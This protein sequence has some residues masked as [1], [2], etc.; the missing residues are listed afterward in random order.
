MS[1]GAIT[2]N[3]MQSFA[4]SLVQP[5]IKLS[6]DV[7]NVIE[8]GGDDLGDDLGFN[9]LANTK[10]APNR[11]SGSGGGGGGNSVSVAPSAFSASDFQVGGLE[12]LEP[13]SIDI[14]GGMGGMESL[15]EVTINKEGGMGGGGGGAMAWDNSQTASGPGIS[16]SAPKRLSPEEERRQK[17]DLINKLGRLESKGFQISKRFTM[18][19]SLDEIEAEFNRLADA[20]QLES[21]MKFQRQMMMGVVTGLELMN[22]KFNPFDWQLEGW[23]ESVHENIDDFDEVFEE[24]YDKY[25]TKGNMPP[26]ARLLFMLV[27]SG[28]MF[29]MSN[30]FFRQKMGNMTMDDLL[31]NNPA[32]AKQ[33]AAAAAQAAGPGFGNFMGAAMGVPQSAPAAPMGMGGMGMGMGG[34]GMGMGGMGGMGGGMPAPMPGNGGP[35]AFFNSAS[36]P[37]TA[38]SRGPQLSPMGA[39]AGAGAGAPAPVRREMKGPSGVDDILQTFQEVRRSEMEAAAAN[40]IFVPPPPHPSMTSG[41]PSAMNA[42]PARA[43]AAELQSIHSEESQSQAGSTM[44]GRT[45]GRRRKAQMPVGN[46]MTLNA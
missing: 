24:L 20:R 33:M 16:L 25:K 18:D 26:E 31:K 4:E 30:S 45:G 7:G 3:E 43:A 27:G 21:S 17:A 35:G 15:P 10:V 19:N 37:A 41:I 39:G 36:M 12:P 42:G 2:I 38:P 9:L 5:D 32:L 40:P 13:I 11:S 14:G 29:H 34:M 23:S 44:T 6:S 8:L 28:F 1:G 46:V 22:N